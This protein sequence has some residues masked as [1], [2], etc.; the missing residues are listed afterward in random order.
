[1]RGV[2]YLLRPLAEGD[3]HVRVRL[4]FGQRS[5]IYRYKFTVASR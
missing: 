1:M 3:H 5:D 4:D 2:F